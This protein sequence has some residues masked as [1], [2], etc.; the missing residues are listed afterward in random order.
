MCSRGSKKHSY[1]AGDNELGRSHGGSGTKIHL[2]TSGSS[3][4]LNFVLSPGQAHESQYA[5]RLLDGIGVQRQNGSMKRRGH[6]VLADKACPEHVLRNE[7]KNKD[8]KTLIPRKSNEKMAS[9][10][11]Q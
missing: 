4:P 8:I 7:L 9:I 3:L 2:A 11:R 1:I 5:L 10:R 6:A